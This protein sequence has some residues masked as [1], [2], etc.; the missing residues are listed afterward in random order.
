MASFTG[1]RAIYIPDNTKTTSSMEKDRW[2]GIPTED[3]EATGLSVRNTDTDSKL[4]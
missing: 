2:Y 3:T 1:K 4:K